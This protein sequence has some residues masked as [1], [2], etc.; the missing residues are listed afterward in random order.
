[1][2]LILHDVIDIVLLVEGKPMGVVS[3]FRCRNLSLPIFL[4]L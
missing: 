1:M 3:D 2:M 4:F